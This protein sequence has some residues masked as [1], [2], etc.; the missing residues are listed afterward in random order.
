MKVVLKSETFSIEIE[1]PREMIEAIESLAQQIDQAKP[2]HPRKT[3][4]RQ[5]DIEKLHE[6]RNLLLANQQ[7]PFS[8][9]ELSKIAGI[10]RTKLQEGFK[11]LFGNTIFG[12]LSDQ[13]LE[14]ARKLIVDSVNISISE[15]AAMSGYKNPQH[16]TAAFKRKFGV[17]P[18][19]VRR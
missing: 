18:R 13:R 8:I 12:Y 4:L 16:F 9:E 17:L 5:A 10:N 3:S 14:D 1:L 11:E 15:V 7:T 2:Q 6:V 19:D